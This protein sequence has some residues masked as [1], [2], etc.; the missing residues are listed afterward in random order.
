MNRLYTL[1]TLEQ[2]IVEKTDKLSLLENEISSRR[3]TIESQP[4]LFSILNN[5]INSGLNEND[6]LM[7]FK[8][9]TIDL[10]NNMPYGN[11]TYL[12]SLKKFRQL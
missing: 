6:I 5:L 9:F 8:I 2:D 3:K 7:A 11:R 12:E 10:C 1:L 4:I